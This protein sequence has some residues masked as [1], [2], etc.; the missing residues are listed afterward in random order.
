[1]DDRKHNHMSASVLDGTGHT[2]N[3]V[4]LISQTMFPSYPIKK[5]TLPLTVH[6]DTN[7]LDN[8]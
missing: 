1:M 8:D 2:L 6:Y 3:V 7:S 4:L 5:L